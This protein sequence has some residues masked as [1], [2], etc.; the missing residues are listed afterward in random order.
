MNRILALVLLISA[1]APVWSAEAYAIHAIGTTPAPY[2]FLEHLPA[3]LKTAP[4][5]KRP[6]VI[7]LHGLGE[8]GASDEK[9]LPRVAGAGPLR[10]IARN[11]PLAKVFVA[12]SAIILAPQGLKSD[13]WWKVEKLTAFLDY[14]LATYPV[15]PDRV[16]VT[17]L[18]MGGGGTWMLAGAAS[19][20]IAAAVPICG[21]AKPNQVAALRS[22]PIWA[23]HAANDPRVKFEE[24]T[25][26]WFDALLA[27]RQA[28]PAGG[29][30]EG[31]P[32]GAK[33]ATATLVQNGQGGQ[34]GWAWQPEQVPPATIPMRQ[35]TL[36]VYA[37]GGH[38]AW[39]RAYADAGMWT[40][41]FAQKRAGAD[42]VEGNKKKAKLA[43]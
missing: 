13:G 9:D 33:V 21:A 34:G 7:F 25:V 30:L 22:L 40:W 8:L 28:K 10:L 42:K 29:A 36:T 15:D 14:A 39:S 5:A 16:Y 18:S 1:V 26:A 3:N 19:D 27:E 38:D 32:V 35:L 41:L 43:K 23:F 6:L 12:Q 37:D 20:R 11:D 4:K 24:H 31:R 17:G 2:G